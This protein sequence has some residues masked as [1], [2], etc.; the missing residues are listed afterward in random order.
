MKCPCRGC[1][2]R[3]VG[4]HGKCERHARWLEYRKSIQAER[5]K[6]REMGDYLR[7]RSARLNKVH[8]HKIR[9]TRGSK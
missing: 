7:E 3:A 4:C 6:D 8:K 5:A 2:E 1:E 9:F